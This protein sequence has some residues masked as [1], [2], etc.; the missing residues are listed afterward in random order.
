VRHVLSKKN[1]ENYNFV[2]CG[3]WTGHSSYIISKILKE[4]NFKNKFYIFDSFEGGL[5]D[6]EKE[7]KS[8]F[9]SLS[10]EEIKD[11]KDY[12]K[13]NENDVRNLLKNFEFVEIFKCWIPEKFHNV[14]DKKFQFIHLDVDLYQPTKDSLEFFYP[15]LAQGGIIVCDDYNFTTFP[16]AKKA[17]DDFF[18]HKKNTYNFFY[19][20]PFGGCF[21]I[22]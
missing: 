12:C 7:D 20:T 21:L 11:Q 22:K 1:L 15:K 16:G 9:A 19:E 2:E 5:S 6:L 14:A 18:K 13:S 4:Y 8:L 10:E 17:W 3:C